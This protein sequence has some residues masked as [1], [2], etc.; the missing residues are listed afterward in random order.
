MDRSE[1]VAR[2]L[3][4]VRDLHR[5]HLAEYRRVSQEMLELN[6]K[7]AELNRKA[8]E[9]AMVQNQ[10]WLEVNRAIMWALFLLI[11]VCVSANLYMLSHAPGSK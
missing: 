2:L 7:A 1:D 5:E 10:R 11:A 6:R 8:T 4:E 9:E 3:V